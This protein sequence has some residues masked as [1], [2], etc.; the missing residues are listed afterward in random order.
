MPSD[1]VMRL[2]VRDHFI[3]DELLTDYWEVTLH[4]L[5]RDDGRPMIVTHKAARHSLMPL[6][7]RQRQVTAPLRDRLHC[8]RV[9]SS[10]V[11][12]RRPVC[13]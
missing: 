3:D 2:V 9:D 11:G 13:P 8:R 4:D 1:N 7:E 12:V 6:S 10:L 5:Q